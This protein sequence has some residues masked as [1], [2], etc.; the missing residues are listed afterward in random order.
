M[1]NM[2]VP[3]PLLIKSLSEFKAMKHLLLFQTSL[4]LFPWKILTP[5][6]PSCPYIHWFH[7]ASGTPDFKEP[8][9][10]DTHWDSPYFYLICLFLPVS[11]KALRGCCAGS[12]YSLFSFIKELR[13]PVPPEEKE[14]GCK[15]FK[16][17]FL[18][19]KHTPTSLSLKLM[20]MLKYS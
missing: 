20:I 18:F 6:L 2:L 9:M 1:Q 12:A 17:D 14:E 4:S 15:L 19:W 16:A 8:V 13:P 7:F 10:W 11:W 5:V 3:F